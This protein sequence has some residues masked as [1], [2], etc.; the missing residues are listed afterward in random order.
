[1]FILL[2][3]FQMQIRRISFISFWL[4]TQLLV[5]DPSA[6]RPDE[7]AF[8]LTLPYA[9]FCIIGSKI[10]GRQFRKE[11]VKLSIIDFCLFTLLFCIIWYICIFILVAKNWIQW[12]KNNQFF[13]KP[14]LLY[15]RTF[16]IIFTCPSYN[17]SLV[18]PA[19]TDGCVVF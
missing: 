18:S 5:E 8:C 1:M 6:E 13:E 9:Y 11:K 4:A 16:S 15:F 3:S 14:L 19:L 12:S 7:C 2:A 10:V 17:G